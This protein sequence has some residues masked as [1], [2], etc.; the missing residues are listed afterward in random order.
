MMGVKG[1]NLT[2]K[3]K[4]GT[5]AVDHV[6]LQMEKG[7]Y[8][9]LGENG[10]GKTTLMRVLT[11]ILKPAEGSVSLNGIEYCEKNYEKIQKKIGYLPQELNL[12]PDLTVRECLEYLGE[13]SEVPAKDCRERIDYYLE[14]TSLT[15][16]QNKKTRQLSGGIKRR[17]GLSQSLLNDPECLVV[18]APTTGLEPEE[19]IRIGNLLV[20][21]SRDRNVLFSTEE[22]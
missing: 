14:K 2:V 1:N 8:G 3:F 22:G 10:A 13:L 6:S 19:R 15:G 4:N 18:D 16:H 20:V 7:I 12:Y 17:V 9:L 5:T 21:W 11:T